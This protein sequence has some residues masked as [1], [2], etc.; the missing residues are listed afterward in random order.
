MQTGAEVR[1]HL[2]VL[3]QAVWEL[4]A[5]V[6]VLRDQATTDV[7]QRRA[8]EGVLVEAGLMV[9]SP[10]GARWG[11]GLAVV[12]G[13]GATAVASQAAA[14]ILQSAALLGGADAWTSQ[15]DDAILAQGRASAQGAHLLNM[16]AV[17]MMEGLGELLCGSS[18]VMLDVGVGVGALAVAFCQEY[19]GLRVVGLDV[20]PRA[21]TLARKS[22]DE[23]GMADRIELR[24]QDVAQLDDRDVFCLGWLPAPFV[25]RAALEAGLPRMVAALVPGGWILFGH[26]MF[27]E[28]G[29]SGALTR[30]QTVAFGGTAIT[31][32]EAHDLLRGVGLE[33]VTS[34]PT[35]PGSPGLTVGRRPI[36]I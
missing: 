33:E 1:A 17:P 30:F 29:L 14:G 3:H 21:L 24:R 34:L 26:G 27:G 32:D 31:I 8:A 20:F 18:P 10:D 19:P 12:V 4:A 23:A 2:N 25:P 13:R 9:A 11:P 22:V 7:D 28:S 5:I 36:H 6:V 16:F 35:P 15:D